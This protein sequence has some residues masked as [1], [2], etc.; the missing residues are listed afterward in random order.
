MNVVRLQNGDV[1]TVL[2]G[3]GGVYDV[4]LVSVSTHLAI[5]EIRSW[6]QVELPLNWVYTR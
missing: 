4:L 2:D 5:G 3:V 1:I 6:K